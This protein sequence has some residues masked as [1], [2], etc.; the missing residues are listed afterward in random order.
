MSTLNSPFKFLNAYT[1]QDQEIF[2]G[3]E[4]EELL[5]HELLKANRLVLV[6]GQSGTGKT[7]LVQCGL[8]RHFDVTDWNPLFV[9][10]KDDLNASLRSTLQEEAG[11]PD[12]DSL[13]SLIEALYLY[14]LRPTYLIFDQFEELLILGKPQEQQAFFRSIAQLL[15][16]RLPC[17]ILLVLREEYIAYL[18]RYE[19]TVPGLFE[20]RL[21]VEP[22]QHRDIEQVILKTCAGFN[23]AFADPPADAAQI[24]RSLSDDERK[25]IQLPY[26][27]VY[28]D[29]L[30]RRV[31][32]K[33]HPAGSPGPLPA[34]TFGAADIEALGKME[35]VLGLFLAEQSRAAQLELKAQF[36]RCPDDLV[37]QALDDFATE[38]GTKRPLPYRLEGD[39][40]HLRHPDLRFLHKLEPALRSACL[41]RLDAG[42]LIAF[43]E[44]VCELRHDSLAVLIDQN[45]S[46]ARRRLNQSYNIVKYGYQLYRQT[47]EAQQAGK[48]LSREELLLIQDHLPELELAPQLRQ[49]VD[50][51]RADNERREQAE[52][53]QLRRRARN[54]YLA[55][56]VGILLAATAIG[57]YF[58]AERHA[59]QA[60]QAL[61]SLREVR[62]GEVRQEI[63]K[64]LQGVD[65]IGAKYPAIRATMLDSAHAKLHTEENQEIESLKPLR[66][67]IG[68]VRK[69][70]GLQ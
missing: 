55:A 47:L 10:R 4:G 68:R 52:K 36:P 31:C 58:Y 63:A 69:K 37:K 44:D 61:Q 62:A 49:F 26:L 7:S 21:R 23:I 2:F 1:A 45:R 33:T 14:Y 30:W 19:K 65:S 11:L 40:L 25:P 34:L 39:E 12:E 43:R 27:Q 41:R 18:N 5:L 32:A 16:E 13:P 70:Y 54:S 28:L 15:A 56:A 9:Y 42:R 20:R 35:D 17:R 53:D 64:I 66:D 57:F 38:D 3:R 22:M 50:D 67:S 48:Y 24:R 8:A 60:E 51:S 29:L 6:Y 46:D 59:K